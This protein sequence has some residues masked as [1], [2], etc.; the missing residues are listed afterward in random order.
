MPGIMGRLGDVRAA[1]PTL[2]ALGL[3]GLAALA[4][5]IATHLPAPAVSGPSTHAAPAGLSRLQSLPL[6]AQSVISSTVGTGDRGFAARHTAAGWRLSGGGVRAD[7]RGGAPVIGTAAG[8]LSL[9]LVG[10]PVTSVSASG[11]RVRLQRAGMQEWYAAG[12]LGIEQGFTLM[13]HPAATEGH[14]LTLSLTVGGALHARGAGSSVDFVGTRDAVAA[15]YGGLTAFDAAHRALPSALRVKDGRVLITVNDRRARYPITIDPLVQQGPKLVPN[16]IQ[17]GGSGSQFGDAVAIAPDG[18]TALIGAQIDNSSTGAAWVFTR[19]DGVWTQLGPKLLPTNGNSQFGT[20]VALSGDGSTALIGGELDSGQTGAAWVFVRSGSAYTEQQKLTGNGEIGAGQFGHSVA[21]SNNGSTALIGGPDDQ[22]A[23]GLSNTGGAAWVFTRTAT[24]WGT[25]TKISP[26]TGPAN[27]NSSNFGTAV[28]LT[29]DGTIALIGGPGDGPGTGVVSEF[30]GP[31]WKSAQRLIPTGEAAP[32]GFGSA[33]AI[34]GDS[35]TAVIGDQDDNNSTG[36][37]AWV[38]T[39]S[40]TTWSQQGPKLVPNNASGPNAQVG[41]SVA[42]S[43]DGN[44]V[45]IG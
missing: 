11:N 22:G 26:T 30:I 25:G 23:G 14:Q 31:T 9:T 10:P 13:H 2:A 7:F 42:V 5:A 17:P 45:L 16:D 40:G 20:S 6:Q 36:G 1:L 24:S 44:T 28:A 33:I 34:S 41:N 4:L 38:F 27:N 35:N 39:R 15:R 18:N 43:G 29:P 3:A 32:S 8:T 37:A 12:P 21:L 19:S